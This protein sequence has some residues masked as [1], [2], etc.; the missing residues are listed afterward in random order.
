MFPTK[1]VEE[2]TATMAAP[3][4]LIVTFTYI[5]CFVSFSGILIFQY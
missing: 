1:V 4:R 5:T 3:M 2:V